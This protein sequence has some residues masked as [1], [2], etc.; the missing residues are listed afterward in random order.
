V[1]KAGSTATNEASEESTACGMAASFS[2]AAFSLWF[3]FY[4][5]ISY[6]KELMAL[7]VSEV[8]LC[9]VCY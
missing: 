2:I 6:I 1:Q 9:F 7:L 5:M 8:I 4:R 3:V